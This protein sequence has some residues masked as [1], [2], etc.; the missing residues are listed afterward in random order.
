M[1]YDLY[2]EKGYVAGGP[3]I[4]GMRELRSTLQ[5]GPA[6]REFADEGRTDQL[7]EL[8]DELARAT[9][10]DPEVAA[11]VRLLLIAVRKANGFIMLWDGVG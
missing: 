11:S 4:S 10:A 1:G 7:R 5:L 9:P 8:S 3:S 6:G 2:D